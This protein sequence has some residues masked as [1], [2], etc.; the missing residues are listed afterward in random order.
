[1]P[2]WFRDWL[3]LLTLV[4][5]W[6]S[7][8]MVTRIALESFPPATLTALRLC[9]GA[10]ALIASLPFINR[11]HLKLNRR[12]LGFFILMAIIG[13]STPFFLISW[14]QQHVNSG[15]AGI[16]MAIMPLATLFLAHFYL[17]NEPLT[18][19]KLIGFTLG[20]LGIIVLMGPNALLEIKTAG[21]TSLAQLAILGGALCYA[22]GTIIARLRP[23]SD[24]LLTATAVLIIGSLMMLP[25]SLSIET[26]WVKPVSIQT[27]LALLFLG[28]VATAIATFVYFRLLR[29]AG[30]TFVSQINYLIPLWALVAG[31]IF[32]DEKITWNSLVALVLI[33]AGIAVAQ[34]RFSM[35]D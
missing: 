16:L 10:I 20:F 29:L 5:I 21:I 26:P 13:N 4:A 34:S 1:M 23:E 18:R 8:F 30:A 6:G 33:L 25:V 22:A 19:K 3:Y 15:L 31:A 32:L 17:P 7:A 11:H 35:K 9:L 27:G 28:L 12:L 24:D 14:G 2:I